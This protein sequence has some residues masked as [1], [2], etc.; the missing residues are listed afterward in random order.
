MSET[1]SPFNF[2]GNSFA[3]SFVR[4]YHHT[5]SATLLYGLRE[6]LA[7]VCNEG[8]AEIIRRHEDTS[9]Y[10]QAGLKRLGLEMYVKNPEH[11]MSTVTA[12]KVPK[13]LDWK[14]IIDYAVNKYV[15]YRKV[16]PSQRSDE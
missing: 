10:L 6:A 11:R 2:D 8:L 1:R 13:E 9:A 15:F 14:A 5:I 12:V 16:H 7:E 3:S 4:S